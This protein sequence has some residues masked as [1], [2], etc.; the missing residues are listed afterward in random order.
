MNSLIIFLHQFVLK[1]INLIKEIQKE[2]KWQK[3][4]E[5]HL[6]KAEYEEVKLFLKK[7]KEIRVSCPLR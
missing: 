6:S 2:V 5:I 1:G 3:S 7:L 4:Q